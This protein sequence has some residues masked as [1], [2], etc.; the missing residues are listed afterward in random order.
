MSQENGSRRQR[1]GRAFGIASDRRSGAAA[2]LEFQD[3]HGG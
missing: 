1:Q 3:K 2:S